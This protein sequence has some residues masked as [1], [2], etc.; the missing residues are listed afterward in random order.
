VLAVVL[1]PLGVYGGVKEGYLQLFTHSAS[2]V[3][4]LADFA[5]IS[6][7][8]V[9][10]FSSFSF[11]PFFR[12]ASDPSILFPFLSFVHPATLLSLLVLNFGTVV[13]IEAEFSKNWSSVS[14]FFF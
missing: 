7:N 13:H 4:H 6:K 9:F 1:L 8:P 2:F 3:R 12:P 14:L 11:S 10:R 5:S